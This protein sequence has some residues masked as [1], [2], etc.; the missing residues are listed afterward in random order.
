MPLSM[1][2]EGSEVEVARITGKTETR[3]HL[4][5]LGFVRGAKV[6]VLSEV[7]GD[8][9]VVVKGVRVAIGKDMANKIMI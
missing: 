5:N 3:K 1:V 7:N 2:S 6:K 4:E 9:I 8:L